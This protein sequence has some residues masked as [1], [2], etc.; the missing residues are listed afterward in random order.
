MSCPR[1]FARGLLGAAVLL[2]LAAASFS[3]PPATS[4]RERKD[5]A[6]AVAKLGSADPAE[7]DE[8]SKAL[9]SIGEAARP[10]LQETAAGDDL[11]AARRATEILRQIRYGIRPDTPPV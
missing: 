9:W 6:D 3:A 1:W 2:L 5:I 8:A 7:R 10:A 4:Q 11:E